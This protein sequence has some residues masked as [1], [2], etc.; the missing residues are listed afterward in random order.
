[1]EKIESSFKILS[2]TETDIK[3]NQVD[4]IPVRLTKSKQ[5]YIKGLMFAALEDPRK[6]YVPITTDELEAD[7]RNLQGC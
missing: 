7:W 1:M 5:D 6:K 4:V 3:G 2:T